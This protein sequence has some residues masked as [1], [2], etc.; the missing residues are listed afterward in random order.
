MHFGMGLASLLLPTSWREDIMKISHTLMATAISLTALLSAASATAQQNQDNQDN[1]CQGQGQCPPPVRVPEP[2][3]LAV[4]A[5]GLIGL[6]AIRRNMK[7]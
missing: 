7:K 1:Q 2:S 3:T 6:A 5:A 4:L